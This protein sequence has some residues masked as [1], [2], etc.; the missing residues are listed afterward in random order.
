MSYFAPLPQD[1]KGNI[2]FYTD[3]SGVSQSVMQDDVDNVFGAGAGTMMFAADIHGHSGRSTAQHWQH[4]L[5]IQSLVILDPNNDYYCGAQHHSNNT[6]ELQAIANALI[7]SKNY[8]GQ[9][10]IR[11]DSEYAIG[12][13]TGAMTANENITMV[14]FIKRLFQEA[15]H[16]AAGSISL[17]SIDN[18]LQKEHS[19]IL[20]HVDAH[21]NEVY[22]EMVDKLA[23]NAKDN[24]TDDNIV[25][26]VQ[27]DTTLSDVLRLRNNSDNDNDGE[28]SYDQDTSKDEELYTKQS[29]ERDDN[30][31]VTD[32]SQTSDKSQEDNTILHSESEHNLFKF[33]DGLQVTTEG[34]EAKF[35][36]KFPILQNGNMQQRLSLLVGLVEAL[37]KDEIQGDNSE[38]TRFLQHQPILQYELHDDVLNPHDNASMDMYWGTDSSG[39]CAIAAAYQVN[40][41]R[42]TGEL[43]EYGGMQLKINSTNRLLLRQY[44]EEQQL[45]I[46]N[47]LYDQN[48]PVEERDYDNSDVAEILDYLKN[49]QTHLGTGYTGMDFDHNEWPNLRAVMLLSPQTCYS[50][51]QKLSKNDTYNLFIGNNHFWMFNDMLLD[52]RN[53]EGRH[54]YAAYTQIAMMTT[55]FES[56]NDGNIIRDCA[57]LLQNTQHYHLVKPVT[58]DIEIN[59]M[60]EMRQ[61]LIQHIQVVYNSNKEVIM[62][63][64]G[65]VKNH[66]DSSL[67]KPSDDTSDV[68]RTVHDCNTFEKAFNNE[69]LLCVCGKVF[70]K[71]HY[72]REGYKERGKFKIDVW[73]RHVNS[74]DHQKYVKKFVTDNVTRPAILQTMPQSQHIEK[75]ASQNQNGDIHQ[76]DNNYAH[77]PLSCTDI[78]MNILDV[79][80]SDLP[81]LQAMGHSP[82]SISPTQTVCLRSAELVYMNK[83]IQQPQEL[84]HWKKLFLVPIIMFSDMIDRTFSFSHKSQLLMQDEW[85]SFKLSAFKGKTLT[86]QKL[87]DLQKLERKEKALQLYMDHGMLSRATKAFTSQAERKSSGDDLFNFIVNKHVTQDKKLPTELNVNP[88]MKRQAATVSFGSQAVRKAMSTL[89]KGV[90]PGVDYHRI[91]HLN[92]MVELNKKYNDA[93]PDA[94]RTLAFLAWFTTQRY[95]GLLPPE[96]LTFINAKKGD[97]IELPNKTRPIGIPTLAE[98]LSDA[99]I[100][101]ARNPP[102]IEQLHLNFGMMKSGSEKF[103]WTAKLGR[104]IKPQNIST[105]QDISDAY[106]TMSRSVIYDEMIKLDPTC[107]P[108]VS[109]QLSNTYIHY[110]GKD[111]GTDHFLSTDGVSQGGQRSA[112]YFCVGLEPQLAKQQ[113]RLGNNGIVRNYIDD[114]HVHADLPG[115]IDN[116]H[117]V[118]NIMPEEVGLRQNQSKRKC[119]LPPQYG[120]ADIPQLEIDLNTKNLMIH[121]DSEYGKTLKNNNISAYNELCMNYGMVITGIPD[122]HPMFI[123]K[124]LTQFLVELDAEVRVLLLIKGTHNKWAILK[125]SI[126]ARVNHIFRG[127]SPVILHEVNFVTRFNSI[128]KDF[129]ADIIRV[130]INFIEEHNF[131]IAQLPTQDGGG[132]LKFAEDTVLPA[133]VASLTTAMN[134]IMEAYPQVKEIIQRQITKTQQ[135]DDVPDTLRQYFH[136]IELLAEAGSCIGNNPV[137]LQGLIDL[138]EK[139]HKG[140]QQRLMQYTKEIRLESVRKRLSQIQPYHFMMVKH[141][142]GGASKEAATIFNVVPRSYRQMDNNEMVG[143]LR[144]RFI[145][146]DPDI[147]EE[148]RCT[149]GQTLDP[150][151][152][153]LQKCNKYTKFTI[154]T[155]EA[156]KDVISKALQIGKIDHV[157]ELC[158]FKDR[159]HEASLRR[160]D[161]VLLNAT[162]LFPHTTKGRGLIDVTVVNPVTNVS[163][164]MFDATTDHMQLA[165]NIGHAA[166]AAEGDKRRKYQQPSDEN[167]MEFIPMAFESQGNW[168]PNSLK[169]FDSIMKRIDEK[170]NPDRV[171]ENTKSNYWRLQISYTIHKFISRHIEDAFALIHTTAINSYS[172][173][174]YDSFE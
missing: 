157:C 143:T 73:Q 146:K 21:N 74:I 97:A 150:Y 25:I 117:Y 49:I 65:I 41:Y 128:M 116:M 161:I 8:T 153:H 69:K 164:W 58:R 139:E 37:H 19:I 102:I 60:I 12:V 39:E 71:P 46:E 27:D 152:W 81:D 95:Q 68:I 135:V 120:P 113:E 2:I 67:F 132:G 34:R 174:D 78:H 22:N 131:N 10:L 54:T 72:F 14:N 43:P 28:N 114:A 50:Y 104:E 105:K 112:L 23:S 77:L 158:P 123:K 171:S 83:I 29:Q 126:S 93:S 94:N 20:Q 127:L 151:G 16:V 90:T 55:D 59:W 129:L 162:T 31:V 79:M 103:S 142:S 13:I 165:T 87:N 124:W 92:K 121:P 99:I 107:G 98:K 40:T 3:G 38:I 172:Q 134:Q 82:L 56:N 61:K 125:Q 147:H 17:N 62:Y 148:M 159:S 156:V 80:W 57:K 52:N 144:R 138:K 70:N 96:V 5:S 84:L 163:G 6:A 64:Y 24:A 168:G 42:E 1:F 109:G 154:R 47:N 137:S 122:G 141:L 18:L 136:S 133:F 160:L 166:K 167:N 44:A 106:Q 30:D 101:E 32:T 170:N 26:T 88:E 149:C 130:D 11:T 51:F 115:S 145:I 4:Q 45:L 85:S 111:S 33:F 91:E 155:H 15:K 140:L 75:G 76:R 100:S 66:H 89:A 118:D 86:V 110:A 169:I 35:T 36:I 7:L 63:E 119:L 9:K 48:I 173:P 53:D 108:H